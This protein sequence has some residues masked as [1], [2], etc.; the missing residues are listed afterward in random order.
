MKAYVVW[1]TATETGENVR[2]HFRHAERAVEVFNELCGRSRPWRTWPELME[3]QFVESATD[4]LI[5]TLEEIDISDELPMA[6]QVHMP[7]EMCPGCECMPG[8]GITEGCNNPV[9]C[10]YFRTWHQSQENADV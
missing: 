6:P 8:D 9:G 7:D 2:K 5:V 3:K 4:D 10:G 1:S